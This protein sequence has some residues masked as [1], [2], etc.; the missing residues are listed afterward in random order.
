MQNNLFM[1]T[2]GLTVAGV[3]LLLK[4]LVPVR[5]IIQ[6]LPAG[7]A[8]N[9]WKLLSSLI[10]IFILGYILYA[11]IREPDSF[12]SISTL[13]VPSIFFGGA[14]FVF[15]VCSLSLKTALDLQRIY[16]LEQESI[17][18]PLTG[19][20]NRR[21]LDRRI[22][23]EFQRAMRFEQ[24]FSVFLLDIDHFKNVND[25]YGHQI[26]DMV[27][28][29][30]SHLITESVREVD[31]AIRY[32]G[33]EIMVILPN[34]RIENAFELA[35]RLRKQI[36]ETIMVAA[37]PRKRQPAIHLTVSIGVSEYQFSDGWDNAQKVLQR[38]DKALYQAKD[39]GRNRVATSKKQDDQC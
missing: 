33:E 27:L 1:M 2:I 14:V 11:F 3:I 8:R 15:L 34:T 28:K 23:E 25:T 6:K 26:G 39:Q 20:F 12:N 35:E 38:A 30:L 24:P 18:D 16:V 29:K 9:R 31:V 13:V 36:E 17:T 19:L 5:V 7:T 21:Y 10:F 32:G 22:V 37:D 4:S